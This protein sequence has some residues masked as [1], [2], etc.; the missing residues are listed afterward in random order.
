MADLFGDA[1]ERTVLVDDVAARMGAA[2][3]SR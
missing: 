1:D 3:R 2:S